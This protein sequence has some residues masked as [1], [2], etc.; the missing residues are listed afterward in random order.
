ML[1]CIAEAHSDAVTVDH[2]ELEDARWFSRS[3]VKAALEAPT[4]DLV[5][6][7]PMAIAHH[8]IR[9]WALMET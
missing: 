6:P 3:E 8:L 9:R 7:P 5:L 1:G 2:R 4:P